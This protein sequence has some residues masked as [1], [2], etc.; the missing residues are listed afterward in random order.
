[1]PTETK[2]SEP[3]M[4]RESDLVAVKKREDKLKEELARVTSKIT[5]LEDD[6]TGI[7]AELKIAKTDASDEDEVVRVREALIAQHDENKKSLKSDRDKFTEELTSF[8][9][10]E[11]EGRVQELA[12]KF[13]VDVEAIQEADDPEKRA[14]ELQLERLTS[15]NEN[16][17]EDIV[18]TSGG[19][20]V[21]KKSIPNMTDEEFA[22]YEKQ[23]LAKA[24]E[25][26]K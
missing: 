19:G 21:V 22:A 9:K 13:K 14:M 2:K 3:K 4:V 8:N 5:Q 15:G 10:R 18:D 7:A 16:S 17:P 26:Q 23:E 1:M 24:Y 6:K 25:K 12:S 11:K 20:G